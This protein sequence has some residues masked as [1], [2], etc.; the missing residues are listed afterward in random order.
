MITRAHDLYWSDRPLTDL[1]IEHV[2]L[3]VGSE[4]LIAVAA[5]LGRPLSEREAKYIRS[6]FPV[7]SA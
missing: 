2:D 4:R 7:V 1:E 3:L 5:R 6:Q